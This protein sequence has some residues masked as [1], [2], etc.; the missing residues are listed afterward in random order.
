MTL[1]R[2][3]PSRSLR[4]VNG[5][6]QRRNRRRSSLQRNRDRRRLE[7]KRKVG[8]RSRVTRRGR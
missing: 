4:A 8:V 7:V 2:C 1:K 5:E 6:R 3:R